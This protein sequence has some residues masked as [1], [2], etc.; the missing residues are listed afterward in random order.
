MG[1][2]NEHAGAIAG[3]RVA[4]TSAAMRQIEQNLNAL[5]DDVVTFMAA[6]AGHEP[7]SAGVVLV[8][9]MVETLRRRQTILR[10]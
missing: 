7:D 6:D 1:N 4:A 9:R 3:F 10:V 5:A 8:R 2:L